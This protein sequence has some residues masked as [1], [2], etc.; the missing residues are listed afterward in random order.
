[1]PIKPDRLRY[2]D[3]IGIIA[4][5]S[6]PPDPKSIEASV[7]ALNSLGFTIKLGRNVR[8]RWG[9]LAGSDRQRANDVMQMFANDHVRA[10]FCLRG[11]YGAAR[12]LPLL[13]YRAIR[14]HPKIFIGYSD[15]TSLHCALLIKCDLISFHGP[16]LASDFIHTDFPDFALQSFLR[17]V[18]Q[19]SAPGA[20]SQG[21]NQSTV[22][23]LRP[24]KASGRLLGGN[25]SILCAT[26]GTPYQPSFKKTV[27]FLEEVDEVPYR[28]DRMLTQLL[29][30]GLLQQVSGVAIGIN[31][32]CKDPKANKTKEYRQSAEDV[33]KER[34]LPLKIPV[35]TGLP[36][37]HTR[38]NAT[39]PI[40]A[41]V[42]LDAYEGDLI[43]T[44]P[45]VK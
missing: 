22:E 19:T 13:D 45:A 3:T 42:T 33:F 11:G 37:G 40:G 6:A 44:E 35:V 30:A 29:N 41:V 10:I 1:M 24:G 38:N 5:A 7:S 31:K 14:A 34:L 21:Y 16:M 27:L 20:I 36:F 23:V 32:N 17:N 2:G 18:M 12:L 9:F 8:Q 43:V 25:L 26:L 4:P 28:L 39:L 15:I